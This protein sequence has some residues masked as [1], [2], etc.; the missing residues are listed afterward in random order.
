MKL[1][2]LPYEL[3][4]CKLK[5]TSDIDL[6]GEFY[7][8]GRTDEE[9]SL[10]CPTAAVPA[11]TVAREDGWKGFKICG[12]LDFSLVGILADISNVLTEC[13]ISI[14][15]LSTYNTDYILVKEENFD[16]AAKALIAHGYDVT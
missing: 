5:S 9:I 2:K 1:L 3:T 10:V 16:N 8:V 6:C 12:V 11:G 7:F 13:G 4:V 14:F 15:A